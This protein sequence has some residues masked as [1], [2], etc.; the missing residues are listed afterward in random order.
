MPK[1][2]NLSIFIQEEKEKELRELIELL[3]KSSRVIHIDLIQL[4]ESVGM[5]SGSEHKLFAQ[6]HAEIL[7][8]LT[9]AAGESEA[10]VI[11]APPGGYK[12]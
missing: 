9:G 8:K 10:S 11:V 6:A 7:K 1:I 2:E 5:I 4:H 12:N 3:I